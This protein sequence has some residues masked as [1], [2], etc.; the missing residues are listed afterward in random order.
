MTMETMI[1]KLNHIAQT[2]ENILFYSGGA[3][4]LSKCSWYIMFW[5]W[6]NGRPNLRQNNSED[7]ILTLT[8][9]GD[10]TKAFTIKQLST[11]KA[12][13]ILGIYLAP[14]GNFP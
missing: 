1:A 11:S 5:E 14:D 2:W 9:Q 8:T 13:K 6:K 4:N 3:L 7:P 12:I 10:Q